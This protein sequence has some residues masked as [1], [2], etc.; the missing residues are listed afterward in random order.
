[1]KRSKFVRAA[2]VVVASAAMSASVITAAGAQEAPAAEAPPAQEVTAP[3]WPVPSGVAGA[4]AVE[5]Q[6]QCAP[7]DAGNGPQT[8]A[9]GDVGIDQTKLDDAIAFAASRLRTN[10]QVFRNNCLI[11]RGPLN[12]VTDNARWNI[13]SSTKSVVSML[14]GI[15]TTQGKLDVNAPI[16]QYLNP[17][18]GDEAHRAITVRDLLTQTSG[19]QQSIVSEGVPSALDLDPSIVEQTLA[20]PVIHEPGT[21]FEYTQRGPDLLAHVIEKAVGEDLQEFA[22]RE[23]FGPIGIG[24]DRYH[25]ARDRSGNT[26]GFA[27]LYLPPTDFARIGMLLL[28][29]GEWN[30]KRIISQDY[31]RDLRTPTA[32]NGCYGYLT[33]VNGMPCTAPSIPSRITYDR[34]AFTGMPAD[35]FATVG[36]LQQN[37]FLIPS[38]GLQVTWNGFLGDVS[39]DPSTV[40]SANPNSELYKTFF[41]KL[42]AAYESP[43]VPDPGP[44]EP[45]F[46]LNV[47]P[48]NLAN[49]DVFTAPFGVGPMAP[50][51]CDIF[52]CGETPL[53][54]P[55]QGN[56]GCFV[57]TCLPKG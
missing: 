38:L 6:Q 13:W 54:P 12:D 33:W 18:Q 14:A 16:G 1:M 32:T 8:A 40:L 19:L 21:F 57:I 24:A 45:T 7:P 39:P 43:R 10:I 30:G 35:T 11:G 22:Q 41:R 15:A 53:R 25:W 28:N 2:L 52:S 51:N 31:M 4:P 5:G 3:E 50:E 36:A 44:Y 37:N 46:N 29:N 23:L 47:D 9:P 20:L 26:Y 49:P 56:E 27:F 17:G 55:L 34:S 48:P 42:V